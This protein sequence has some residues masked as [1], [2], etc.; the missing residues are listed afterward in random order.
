MNFIEN[1]G[2]Q[3]VPLFCLIIIKSIVSSA[4]NKCAIYSYRRR[5]CR[6]VGYKSHRFYKGLK[7]ELITLYTESYFDFAFCIFLSYMYLVKAP[8]DK[9]ARS[10]LTYADYISYGFAC[11]CAVLHI[12][13]PIYLINLNRYY[14]KIDKDGLLCNHRELR[15]KLR[16]EPLC[17][18]Q[19]FYENI[20]VGHY[21]QAMYQPIFLLRRLSMAFVLLYLDYGGE[22]AGMQVILLLQASC[23]YCIYILHSR[24]LKTIVANQ[25]EVQV[26]LTILLQFYIWIFFTD[27]KCPSTYRLKMGYVIVMNFA[28]GL[29]ATLTRMIYQSIFELKDN[30]GKY[31]RDR[32]ANMREKHNIESK[33]MLISQFPNQFLSLQRDL[34]Q[35]E[36]IQWCRKYRPE[37]DWMIRN[38][39]HYYDLPEEVHFQKQILM[40]RFRD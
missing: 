5:W 35:R 32:E 40:Y 20:D 26:E 28:L 19:V 9:E 25:R 23:C 8:Q 1:S 38:G 12:A 34:Q 7:N 13:Y 22:L 36:A 24:P 37:R 33:R 18:E 4:L 21:W 15:R 29:L 2:S 11:I 16:K 6:V 31:K 17:S 14:F 30:Y 27:S 10:A 3:I 39:L